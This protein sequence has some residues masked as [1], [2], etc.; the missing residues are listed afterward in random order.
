[1]KSFTTLND[2]KYV[3]KKYKNFKPLILLIS[4]FQEF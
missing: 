4:L 2:K 3:Y 1:M